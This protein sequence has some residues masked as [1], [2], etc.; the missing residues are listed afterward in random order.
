[1]DRVVYLLGA[2]F[3]APLGLPA[4]SN[5]LEKS[6][7]LYFSN[8]QRYKYFNDVLQEIAKM[9][10]VKNYYST[11]LFNIEE[12]LSVL[13][14]RQGLKGRRLK[15]SF[16]RYI[17]DVINHYTPTIAPQ[18]TGWPSNWHGG[19]F[20]SAGRPGQFFGFF[21]G[22]LLQLRLSATD[23]TVVPLRA[24]SFQDT[25]T[26]Y[27]VITLNY[28]MVLENFVKYITDSFVD[29]QFLSFRRMPAATMKR[30][31]NGVPLA[32]LHGSTDT[33]V[34]VAPTWNK[35]LIHDL[36]PAWK[37]AFDLLAKANHIRIIGYSLPTADSYI[38]YLLRAAAIE[39]SHLKRIDVI[40]RD[41]RKGLVESRYSEFIDFSSFRFVNGDVVSYLKL[42]YEESTKGTQIL[43]P[44]IELRGLE[45]AHEE[46][47]LGH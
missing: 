17:A 45:T 33:G 13:A 32:K 37:T 31:D 21:V 35:A 11:D 27:A 8:P 46:F 39:S 43:A 10:V 40:C 26:E 19:I 34:I 16:L 1:M 3:S 25:R 7:D 20:S 18:K 12:I 38:K 14:M 28:D 29:E 5:F 22:S 24:S 44:S 30:L 23:N 9:S 41:D 47:F 2:G 36:L 42:I 4:M 6:R 15:A